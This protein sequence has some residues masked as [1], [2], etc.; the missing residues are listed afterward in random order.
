MVLGCVKDPRLPGQPAAGWPALH[1]S[2]RHVTYN[3]LAIGYTVKQSFALVVVEVNQ[4]IIENNTR[5]IYYY[6]FN[7]SKKDD[8]TTIH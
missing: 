4:F 7:F 2:P 5:L 3:I 8:I 6:I 1:H